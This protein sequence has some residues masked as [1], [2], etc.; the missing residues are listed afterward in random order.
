MKANIWKLFLLV[1]LVSLP[2]FTPAQKY[3]FSKNYWHKGEILLNSGQ[4]FQ[5]LIKYH[6]N[7]NLLELKTDDA[8][9]SKTFGSA[10]V[11]QFTIFDTLTKVERTFFALPTKTISGYSPAIFYELVESGDFEMLTREKV[12]MKPHNKGLDLKGTGKYDLVLEDDFYYLNEE[13]KAQSCG[14]VG[15]L[16][17]LIEISSVDLKQYIKSNKINMR[18]RTDFINLMNHFGG[19]NSKKFSIKERLESKN[20]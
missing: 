7:H 18:Q 10:Q 3:L 8:S 20:R 9:L 14:E 6:L 11:E 5:G 13:G 15:T 2:S 17:S 16:A 19:A 4:V 12:V 1:V